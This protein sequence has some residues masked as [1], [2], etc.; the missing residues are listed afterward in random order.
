MPLVSV[1]LAVHN[2]SRYLGDAVD[3]VLGQ[4]VEDL[5]LIVIDDASTDETPVCWPESAT[6]G[7]SCS[8]TRSRPGSPP[9]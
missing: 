1:L 9:R 3:S 4:T 2:G 5:E 8:A 7:S 6:N